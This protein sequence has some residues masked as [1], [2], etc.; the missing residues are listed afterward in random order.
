MSINIDGNGLDPAKRTAAFLRGLVSSGAIS[1]SQA[2]L[3]V[4]GWL[5]LEN[6]PSHPWFRNVGE[7]TRAAIERFRRE[8]PC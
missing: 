5:D 6:W 4:H 1:D 3:L 8:N 2:D 7:H